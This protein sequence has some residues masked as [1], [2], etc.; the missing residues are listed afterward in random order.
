V[1]LLCHDSYTSLAPLLINIKNIFFHGVLEE[2]IFIEQ[3]LG[4]VAQGL[5]NLVCKLHWSL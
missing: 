2:E 3:L 1:F 5:F 4:C